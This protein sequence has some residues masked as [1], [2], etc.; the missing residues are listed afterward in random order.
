MSFN[1]HC[2]HQAIIGV[3]LE[4]DKNKKFDY[5][6]ENYSSLDQQVINYQRSND[7]NEHLTVIDLVKS[8]GII[9]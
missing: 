3:K 4:F 8:K 1:Y 6:I 5:N 7:E 9:K 2:E